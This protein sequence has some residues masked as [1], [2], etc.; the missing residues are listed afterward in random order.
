MWRFF[1]YIF[2]CVA[3]ACMSFVGRIAYAQTYV[4]SSVTALFPVA[5][6]VQ[7]G[8][9]ISFDP[10]ALTYR[11]SATLND[12]H[13]F[14]VVV[15]DPTLFLS[16]G[17][18]ASGTP[19]VRSGEALVNVSDLGGSIREGDLISSS[20]IPG[21]G[22]KLDIYK[23]GYVLGMALKPLATSTRT[24]TATV[25][26]TSVIIGKV[27]V[28][29]RI[30]SYTPSPE[31]VALGAQEGEGDTGAGL[32]EGQVAIEKGAAVFTVD[33]VTRYILAALIAMLVLYIAFR[34][35]RGYMT[36]SI[37]SVGRNPLAKASI[38]SMVLLN[39]VLIIIVSVIALIIGA[40]I[41]YAP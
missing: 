1:V 40:V 6:I 19:I 38:L 22:Q 8:D 30:S 39:S 16:Q 7:D 2:F 5:S 31:M 3:F 20:V 17:Q 34:S 32:K 26:G 10:A 13:M 33:R 4:D 11:K 35:F 14:G 36:Q 12:Q 28:A 18:S 9:I 41:I 15:T 24:G 29:L 21:V 27:P 23:P 37:I 25:D